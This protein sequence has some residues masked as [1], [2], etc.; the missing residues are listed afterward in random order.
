MLNL[1]IPEHIRPLRTKVLNFIEQEIYPVEAEL[2]SDKVASRRGDVLK[3]LMNS[4]KAQGLWAY[5]AAW[6]KARAR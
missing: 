4:A 1:S 3:G 6:C 5:C 2:V